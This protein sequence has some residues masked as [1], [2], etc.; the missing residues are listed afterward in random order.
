MPS[1]DFLVAH[2]RCLACGTAYI[3]VGIEAT[4]CVCFACDQ[5]SWQVIEVWHP[6]R[7]PWVWSRE[8]PP[9]RL[10]PV[11]TAAAFLAHLTHMIARSQQD[12]ILGVHY[13]APGLCRRRTRYHSS[14]CPCATGG[15]GLCEAEC[16]DEVTYE[17][18]IAAPN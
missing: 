7:T 2:I 17:R 13:A 11:Q 18:A 1:A 16:Q 9:G 10:F 15:Y 6:D 12:G 4:R 3:H 8:L 14:C 5:V